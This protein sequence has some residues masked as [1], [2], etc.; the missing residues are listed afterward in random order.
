[1][2]KPKHKKAYRKKVDADS[3]KEEGPH[4]EEDI[5][6]K[7][8]QTKELQKLRE[9]SKG[10]NAGVGAELNL[11]PSTVQYPNTQTRKHANTQTHK[12]TNTPT[13]HT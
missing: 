3:R 8:L 5:S 10:V 9:R 1:M 13:R 11:P 6:L 7:L 4:I 2:S 12:H